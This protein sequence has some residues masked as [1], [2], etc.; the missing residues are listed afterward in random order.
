MASPKHKRAL[1]LLVIL[2]DFVSAR[3]GA[4]LEPLA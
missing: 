2:V 3:S 4:R 1:I